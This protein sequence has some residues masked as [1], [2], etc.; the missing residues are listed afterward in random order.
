MDHVHERL[1]RELI[2]REEAQ[3]LRRLRVAEGL[4]DFASNDYL[5]FARDRSLKTKIEHEVAQLPYTG[6][7]GS[8]LLTGNNAYVELVEQELADFHEAQAALFFNSGYEANSGLISTIVHRHDLIFYDE[9]VHASLREG[10]RLSGAKAYSFAH[11]DVDSLQQLLEVH[12]GNVFVV[13]ESVFSM[14]G[15]IAPLADIVSL[16]E[17]HQ[18]AIILDEAHG[19][20]V[21]GIK[22][23]GL[24]QQLALHTRIF[25]R[26]HTFGK[27]IGT[28]GAVVLGSQLLRDYLINFCKPF[29]YTTA[30]N[31]LQL[32]SVRM[33]YKYLTTD[34]T[35]LSRL[36]ENLDHM[37]SLLAGGQY[38]QP[39][40]TDSAIFSFVV[41]GNGRVRQLA[42]EMH[43]S[44]FDMRP[45]LSPTVPAG[46]ERIRMCMHAYNTAD[47][48][49]TAC[50]ALSAHF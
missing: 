30:P 22:G 50:K 2:A 3:A 27:A 12:R 41:P 10:I 35:A 17:K 15:D 48:I 8:R 18:A 43:N 31:Y 45:I 25:A 6:S 9:L 24:A 36:L 46:S 44:G 47:E 33:A 38:P 23:D 21:L 11:N 34:H 39:V 49:A 14:D 40:A 26:V 1:Q 42:K 29:I 5:G 32:A 4:V 37:R 28:N 19:T 13:T 7:G 20:G 16:A